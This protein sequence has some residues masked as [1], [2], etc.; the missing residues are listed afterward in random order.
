MIADG[1]LAAYRTAYLRPHTP[2]VRV[3]VWNDTEKLDDLPIWG[4]QVECTLASRVTR[5]GSL[6]CDP[7][8]TPTSETDLLAPFGNR[9]VIKR[10]LSLGGREFL[11]P[12]FTGMI[13]SAKRKS[14]Q[15][16]TVTFLDRANEVDENDFEAAEETLPGRTLVEE[17]VRLIR[18]GVP[19]AEFGDHDHVAIA[20]ASQVF[21]DSRSQAC[22]QLADAGGMFWY[23]LADGRFVVRRVPWTYHPDGADVE[24]VVEYRDYEYPAEAGGDQRPG[25]IVDAEQGMSREGVYNVVVGVADTPTG[26]APQRAS[27][28]DNDPSSPTYI[29]GKFGRRVLRVEFPSASTNAVVRHGADTVRR[30]SR[31]SADVIPWEMI[32]D[33][34][35]ELGD[36][37]GLNLG[38]DTSD[39][40]LL[41]I[42]SDMTIPLVPESTMSCI[43]RPLVL[44]SGT[45][46]DELTIF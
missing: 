28:R 43:G 22:D 1:L 34:S 3:E 21:D 7:K 45:V 46:L 5:R 24:P 19:R 26:D 18:E 6:T 15:P 2:I 32:P 30:R 25:S 40:T 29:G 27:A 39:R 17:I 14:R 9:L 4:G 38:T 11:F 23:A 20:A 8:L 37:V 12:V 13:Q 36:P 41:R 42:V 10:G 31:A 33:A 35:L 44:P 16:L